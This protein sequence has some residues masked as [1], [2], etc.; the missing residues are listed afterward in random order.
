[1]NKRVIFLFFALSTI[2]NDPLL[3][4]SFPAGN[5]YR[6]ST[7]FRPNSSLTMID[8]GTR[9]TEMQYSSGSIAQY[10]SFVDAGNGYF[11][12]INRELGDGY[13]LGIWF[14]NGGYSIR[15]VSNANNNDQFWKVLDYGNGTYS[16]SNLSQGDGKSL[17]I[18]ND[19]VYSN[20]IFDDASPSSTVAW[21]FNLIS[22]IPL[23]SKPFIQGPLNWIRICEE[24]EAVN[25]NTLV[26]VA[27]G[28]KGSYY[29]KYGVSGN[30]QFNNQNFGDPIPGDPKAGFYRLAK[31]EP[32]PQPNNLTNV[33]NDPIPGNDQHTFITNKLL[34][35]AFALDFSMASRSLVLQSPIYNWKLSPL[36]GGNWE[37]R[38]ANNGNLPNQAYDGSTRYGYV[39]RQSDKT[40]YQILIL[41]NGGYW[42]LGCKDGIPV[43]V[44]KNNTDKSQLWRIDRLADDGYYKIA[45]V[46]LLESNSQYA[47]LFCDGE[48]KNLFMTL[49]DDTKS[50]NGRWSFIPNG[51][52]EINEGNDQ[53]ENATS[54]RSAVNNQP[55]CFK[56][57]RETDFDQ[58]PYLVPCSEGSGQLFFRKTITGQY[59]IGV[60]P[61]VN[62]KK[63]SYMNWNLNPDGEEIDP[64]NPS[65]GYLFD[66][67][68]VSDRFYKI[69]F[70]NKSME[71]VTYTSMPHIQMTD[72][73][74]KVEQLWYFQ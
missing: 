70:G 32:P 2:L 55:I 64:V 45:N 3:S 26:D 9:R 63:I 54:L 31:E 51:H 28:A 5:W 65:P 72:T 52:V 74:V 20:V 42:A 38:D 43:I 47:F 41:I 30:I 23:P 8:A 69:S 60:R 29:Y 17:G 40:N 37:R 68:K 16:I 21:T 18:L 13:S 6:L 59:L 27:Y 66:I 46:G 62:D 44:E 35:D 57:V 19:G 50:L 12:L 73:Q 10:W 71:L 1:M 61:N 14:E 58:T 48:R 4:Q 67:I 53:W 34:G 39:W 49:W 22:E 15:L 7:V 33:K 25:F 24:N 56:Y 36:A 11:R